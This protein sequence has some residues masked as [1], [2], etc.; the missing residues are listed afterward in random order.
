MDSP[1]CFFFFVF[2]L[3]KASLFLLASPPLPTSPH[4]PSSLIYA[5]Q[6]GATLRVQ[7][8]GGQSLSQVLVTE[9]LMD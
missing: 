1:R 9:Q 8:V 3:K 6:K 5:N 4:P 7:D 2:L